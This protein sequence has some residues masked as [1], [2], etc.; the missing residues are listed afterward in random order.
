MA[1]FAKVNSKNIVEQV[2]VVPDEQENRGEEYLNEIGLEGRWIQTSFNNKIRGR[3]AAISMI[4]NE[5][6]DVFT[7]PKPYNSWILDEYFRWTAPIPYP[8][9]DNSYEWDESTLSWVATPEEPE[10]DEQTEIS[11]E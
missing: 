10:T 6:L 11:E 8:N 5:D 3:F 1:H 4:Y 9:D 2:L 7:D